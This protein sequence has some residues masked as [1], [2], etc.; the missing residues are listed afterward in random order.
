VQGVGSSC[1]AQLSINTELKAVNNPPREGFVNL[2]NAVTSRFL[3]EVHEL[4]TLQSCD[5][6]T[7]N[8]II[9]SPVQT[10]SFYIHYLVFIIHTRSFFPP[11]IT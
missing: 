7:A 9:S 6:T 8:T 1:R 5:V 10:V 4:L 11:E 3:A 2:C